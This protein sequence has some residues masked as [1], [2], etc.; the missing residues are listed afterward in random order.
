LRGGSTALV[1][2]TADTAR[3]LGAAVL[4]LEVAVG[5]EAA[6]ALYRRLG[7]AEAGRRKG[8]YAARGAPPQDALVLRS[9]LP[10]SPLGKSPA[11]G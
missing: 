1:E 8:Y 9:N 7:F 5:N 6:L 3:R 4:F 2:A 11:A 10:L